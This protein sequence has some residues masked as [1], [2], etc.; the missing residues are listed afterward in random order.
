MNAKKLIP[1]L[2]T[3]AMLAAC[4]GGGGGGGEDPQLATLRQENARLRTDLTSQTRIAQTRQE[5]IAALN[6]QKTDIEARLAALQVTTQNREAEIAALNTQKAEIEARLAALRETLRPT[7]QPLTIPT[8]VT[9]PAGYDFTNFGE[10]SNMMSAHA[11]LASILRTYNQTLDTDNLPIA[12][13]DTGAAM[14]WQEGWTGKGVKIGHLDNFL[15]TTIRV[16]RFAADQ[17]SHGQFVRA[18]YTQIAPEVSYSQRQ[19]DLFCTGRQAGQM[20]DAFD[21]FNTNGFHILN[22][23]FGLN[24]YNSDGCSAV[25]NPR[26]RTQAQWDAIVAGQSADQTFLKYALPSRLSDT[27]NSNL[28]VVMSAGNAA[29]NCPHHTSGCKLRAAALLSLRAQTDA[30]GVATMADAGDRIIFVGALADDTDD[31]AN[32]NALA[33]YSHAAGQMQN[34]YIVAHDDIFS[35]G[36]RAGTSFAAP[37]VAGAAALVRH[38]FPNLTGPQ[39]KQVLLQTAIDLDASTGAPG[40]DGPDATYGY[41]KLSIPNALSPIGRV[42]A[43]P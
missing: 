4:G 14:A 5:E 2:M 35:R 31:D 22:A 17:F 19:I 39:L 40:T 12:V 23:S 7:P 32:T 11:A 6:T 3:T 9:P 13:R 26:L 10:P 16:G 20:S 29:V 28:L 1:I 30:H 37:R 21:Y 25:P 34:D 24:R 43:Q 36:D 15:L 33:S 38:K 18:V 8:G 27:Y 41:G 42:R